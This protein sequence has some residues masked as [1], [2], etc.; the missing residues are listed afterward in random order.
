MFQIKLVIVW[1]FQCCHCVT[2]L[3]MLSLCDAFNVDINC[4]P[5]HVSDSVLRCDDMVFTNKF[6]VNKRR[7]NNETKIQTHLSK[8]LSDLIL[9]SFC[10]WDVQVTGHV[11]LYFCPS[12]GLSLFRLIFIVRSY[13][14]LVYHCPRLGEGWDPADMFN[15]ATLCMYVPVPS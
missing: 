14:V 15:F 1:C 3:S 7:N 8:V 5:C 9:V 10:C 13:V 11:H 4:I 6:L 12:D 2:M